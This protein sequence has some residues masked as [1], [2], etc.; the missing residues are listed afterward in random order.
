MVL[1]L[2]LGLGLGLVNIARYLKEG[3]T[4]G[5]QSNLHHENNNLK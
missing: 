5:F 3:G 2:G 1:G 4:D